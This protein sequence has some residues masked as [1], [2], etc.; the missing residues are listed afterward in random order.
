MAVMERVA[1]SAVVR[2]RRG[3]RPVLSL[4]TAL[5]IGLVVWQTATWISN[6]WIPSVAEIGR[7]MGRALLS[8]AFW[9]A[10]WITSWRI[11]QAFVGATV[12]G[13]VVGTAMGLNRY[14]EAF[15]RPLTVI[16]LAIPDPVYIIFA[17]LIL[18]TDESSGV[19]ALTAAVLPFVITIVHG[20]VKAR[21]RQL[22]D[23]SRVYRF[24]RR[25]HVVHVLARQIAPSLVVAARTSFAFCWKIVVLVEAISQPEGVGAQIYT[26]FRLLRADELVAI[27]V[28]FIV[29]MR[30]VDALVFGPVE[31]RLMTWAQ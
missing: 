7:A 30:V 12:L 1:E 9:D 11:L 18:G 13:I 25:R 4:L 21:D 6:G 17:I 14:V 20:S 24:G 26:A 19:I 27:A 31:R 3:P 23:M 15:F 29:I 16:A 5:A 22:D 2:N 8:A 28:L 10:A